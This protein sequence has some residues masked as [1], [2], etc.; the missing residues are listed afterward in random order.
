[1]MRCLRRFLH[2]GRC[3][4]DWRCIDRLQDLPR[5]L[6]GE[7]VVSLDCFDTLIIRRSGLPGAAPAVAARLLATRSGLDQMG[8]LDRRW[9]AERTLR[10]EHAAAGDDPETE[11]EEIWQRVCAGETALMGCA[12]IGSAMERGVELADCRLQPGARQVVEALRDR[13]C[14]VWLVSD[15]PWRSEVLRRLC[16]RAGLP[17]LATIVSSADARRSKWSGRLYDRLTGVAG[18]PPAS[19]LHCGDHPVIDVM[20]ARAAGWH[21]VPFR[22]L[23]HRLRRWCR[24]RQWRRLLAAGMDH[25]DH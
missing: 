5:R 18:G 6:R 21:A 7:R 15:A 14:Q 12:R 20:R 4:L 23:G 16:D 17:A 8:L 19:I 24:H 10:A 9:A 3:W 25:G 22:A 11:V 13:G 2:T 1:M